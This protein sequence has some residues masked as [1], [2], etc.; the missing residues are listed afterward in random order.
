MSHSK[1]PIRNRGL[2]AGVLVL[3]VGI[4]G[5]WLPNGV[6][7][8]AGSG[9][10]GYSSNVTNPYFPLVPGR[11][12]VYKGTK[13]GK[14]AVDY[15]TTTKQ[16]VQVNNQPCRLVLDRLF[17]AGSLAETTADYYTQ[18]PMGNVHYYGED[19]ATI[20]SHGNMQVFGTDGSW[21]AA[22]FGAIPGIFMPGNPVPGLS[23]RQ[24]FLKGQ[25]EDHFQVLDLNSSITVPYGSFSHVLQTKEW[26]PLE[27]G[28]L[29][30]KY[31]VKGIG[32]VQETAVAGPIETLSLTSVQQTGPRFEQHPISAFAL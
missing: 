7:H 19:T 5:L 15:F 10:G 32:T 6:A 22:E 3:I 2:V 18:D 11:T 24:E 28:V 26:T 29:D 9:G 4:T 12:L 8:S 25:A 23:G 13:D 1:S 30:N 27:P 14:A 20:D 17:L 16:T 21:R 31:Y